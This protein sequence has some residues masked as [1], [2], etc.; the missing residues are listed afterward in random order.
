MYQRIYGC[1]WRNIWLVGDLHGCFARLMAALR[2]RKFDPYQDLLL[3]VGDLNDRGPQS[4]ECLDLLRYRWVYAVR[5]NHEQMALEALAD[6]DMR[7]W[8]LNGGDWYTQRAASQKQRLT[9]LIA[10]CR[11]LPLII[12]LHSGEQVHVIAHAD[13]PAAV[14]R[15]QRIVDEQQV[16][17]RRQRLTDHLAGR[18]G[19]IAGADHFWFGHTPLKRRYD[20]DNQH[21]IDTGAVFGGELTLVALQLAD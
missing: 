5:G 8:E 1:D 6:G 2:E 14:Y 4:A 10:R 13:Y 21:Y 3:S 11:R 16:M 9:A 12:E 15:W 19:A 17:W 18:H 20:S 7:L